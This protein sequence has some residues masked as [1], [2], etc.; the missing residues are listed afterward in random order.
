MRRQE[1]VRQRR[2]RASRIAP[3][4]G[5][6]AQTPLAVVGMF[7]VVYGMEWTGWGGMHMSL[8]PCPT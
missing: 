2:P 6:G 5:A 7:Y 3:G 4:K 8:T 1:C